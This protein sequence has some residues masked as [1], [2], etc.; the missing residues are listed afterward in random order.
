MGAVG[1]S[2]GREIVLALEE[3]RK[4]GRISRDDDGR[5]VMS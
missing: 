2:D 3:L 4:E 5:Y 1:S